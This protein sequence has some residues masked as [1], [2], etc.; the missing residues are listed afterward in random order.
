[1]N[2]RQLVIQKLLTRV[3]VASCA[4]FLVGGCAVPQPAPESFAPKAMA[5]VSLQPTFRGTVCGASG[6]FLHNLSRYGLYAGSA[7]T[8]YCEAS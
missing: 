5:P 1:M 7:L 3:V 8:L 4:G 2:K 6:G